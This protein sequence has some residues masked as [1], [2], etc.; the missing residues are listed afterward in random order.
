[1]L[2]PTITPRSGRPAMTLPRSADVVVVGSGIVGAACA[3]ALAARGASV[4]LL[5]KEDG[6][7]REGSGRA[8]FLHRMCP[9]GRRIDAKQQ[10]VQ[11]RVQAGERPDATEPAPINS[12]GGRFELSTSR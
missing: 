12:P 4:V 9:V 3:A 2:R 7:A 10:V 11:Q 6:P 8:R 5:E 1:M